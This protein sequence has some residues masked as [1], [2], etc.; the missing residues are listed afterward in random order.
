MAKRVAVVG[1][2]GDRRKFGNKAFRAF[3]HQGH[4]VIPVNP[5]EVEIEGTRTVASVLDIEGPLDMV[6]VYVPPDVGLRIV[7]EVAKKGTGELWLNPGADT[8]DVVSRARELGLEPIRACS[9]MG[10]GEN[11]SEY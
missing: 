6:T 9:I 5:N 2:S 10:I 1:A 3:R 11:P 4:D 7:E 8:D